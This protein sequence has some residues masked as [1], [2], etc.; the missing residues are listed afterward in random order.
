MTDKIE[1]RLRVVGV[2]CMVVI[3]ATWGTVGLWQHGLP[4]FPGWAWTVMGF[5]Y[6]LGVP[7]WV[8]SFVESVERFTEWSIAR[9]TKKVSP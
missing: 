7:G 6:G 2:V 4:R 3:F 5:V 1:L 8:L 9:A